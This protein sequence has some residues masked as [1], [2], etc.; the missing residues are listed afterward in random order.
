MA[1]TN[2]AE[3][4]EQSWEDL[5]D[6]DPPFFNINDE[7]AVDA[8]DALKDLW[9]RLEL[10]YPK[11]SWLEKSKDVTVVSEEKKLEVRRWRD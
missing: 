11:P 10:M 2:N 4:N 1:W 6:V 9:A 7:M 8:D 3:K 5:K